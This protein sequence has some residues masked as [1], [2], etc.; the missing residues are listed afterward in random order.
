MKSAVG[1]K[2]L[3]LCGAVTCLALSAATAS[4]QVSI[5][6]VS[7]SSGSA[8]PGQTTDFTFSA[9]DSNGS[10]NVN[11][12]T[13]VISNTDSGQNSC[14][15]ALFPGIGQAG[16]VYLFNDAGVTW[17]PVALGTSQT[18]NNSHCTV[19]GTNSDYFAVGSTL[20]L[21]LNISFTSAWAGTSLSLYEQV[22]DNSGASSG[23]WQIPAA[24]FY[25]IPSYTTY[26]PATGM[27][28]LVYP[29]P[30]V[31]N[32]VVAN[33]PEELQFTALDQNGYQDIDQMDIVIT[34]NGTSTNACF[35]VFFPQMNTI[36]VFDD[37]AVY[38][39]PVQLNPAIRTPT[40]S[41]RY[42]V[43]LTKRK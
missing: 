7:P 1:V 14:F 31:A 8:N 9:N 30:V 36:Y 4:A 17:S 20:Y 26:A 37:N 15:F 23:W 24:S 40:A 35:M 28:E 12:V 13:V 25:V 11:M 5:G 32:T 3:W 42:R 6:T 22:T 43:R 33:V 16:T 2:L 29:P 19:Y 39:C 41:A 27:E 34:P 21:S 18:Y 38:W 10:W